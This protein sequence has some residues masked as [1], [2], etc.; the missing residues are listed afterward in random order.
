MSTISTKSTTSTMS[1]RLAFSIS[2]FTAKKVNDVYDVSRTRQ[3]SI[4]RGTANKKCVCVYDF[5]DICD[6]YE[7]CDV[8]GANKKGGKTIRNLFQPQK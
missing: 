2:M 7:V 1:P 3:F 4:T 8:Y 6:I 5:C